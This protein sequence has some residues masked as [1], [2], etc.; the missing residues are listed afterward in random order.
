MT[1]ETFPK[2]ATIMSCPIKLSELNRKRKSDPQLPCATRNAQAA[3][4]THAQKAST[5]SRGELPARCS[6]Q[7][8]HNTTTSLHT[9]IQLYEYRVY[10]QGMDRYWTTAME[11][12]LYLYYHPQ[13]RRRLQRIINKRGNFLN[14]I[15]TIWHH[16]VRYRLRLRVG[17]SDKAFMLHLYYLLRSDGVEVPRIYPIDWRCA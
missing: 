16:C 14:Q 15:F 5:W 12:F 4:D 3:T 9:M 8:V 1:Q 17:Q 7:P 10:P 6:Q 2:H 11:L 13:E